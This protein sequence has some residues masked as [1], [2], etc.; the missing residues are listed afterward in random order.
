MKIDEA[1]IIHNQKIE[2]MSITLMNR[3]LHDSLPKNSDRYFSVQ[4][5]QE[6]WP[7]GCFQVP[8][9]SFEILHAILTLTQIPTII[10]AQ[11]NG[12]VLKVDGVGE[13]IVEWHI[14]AGMK[15]IKALYG[16][17]SGANA[18]FCCIYCN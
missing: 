11:D 6:I 1:E 13:F 12:Q 14:A 7:V 18:T 3:A 9:E 15:T 8:K 5:E 10:Q 2:R 17:N 4:S 16:L